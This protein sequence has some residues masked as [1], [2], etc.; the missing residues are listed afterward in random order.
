[1]ALTT[2][3]TVGVAT[4]NLVRFPN[5]LAF[6]SW[7][8]ERTPKKQGFQLWDS[9]SQPTKFLVTKAL[10]NWNKSCVNWRIWPLWKKFFHTL[11]HSSPLSP[12]LPFGHLGP[13]IWPPLA[14]H[15]FICISDEVVQSYFSRPISLKFAGNLQ[16]IQVYR[17]VAKWAEGRQEAAVSK[18]V[19]E[20]FLEWP[21]SSIHAWLIPI[22]SSFSH[23][24]ICWL[25]KWPSKLKS[26]FFRGSF[27]PLTFQVRRGPCLGGEGPS[28]PSSTF[29][30]LSR[31]FHG[32]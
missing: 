24:K 29:K 30:G 14:S 2:G 16:Q 8:G 3:T 1:M 25:R 17:K 20:F 10:Q 28:G 27:S 6:G 31:V 23:Q 4:L 32:F 22:L 21:K 7:L 13:P 11:G 19:K 15:I 26:L 5:Q 9:F 18:C 12:F